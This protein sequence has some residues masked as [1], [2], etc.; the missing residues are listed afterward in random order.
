M[1]KNSCHNLKGTGTKY[2]SGK[3]Q[4]RILKDFGLAL[5]EVS[6]V[7]TFGIN[8][9]GY[10]NWLEVEEALTR[11]D[12]AKGR[13]YLNQGLEDLDNQTGLLHMAHECWNNLA[14]L[15]LTLR[16]QRGLTYERTQ[17]KGNK[18]AAGETAVNERRKG[19]WIRKALQKVGAYLLQMGNDV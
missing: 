5:L 15:E 7:G 14:V 1:S 13:H 18:K 4:T 16:E 6:K 2:D 12:D 9:Y 10:K 17:S 3:P 19:S 8:E 11:F